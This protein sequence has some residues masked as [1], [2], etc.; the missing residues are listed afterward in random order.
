MDTNQLV[1]DINDVQNY[2]NDFINIDTNQVNNLSKLFSYINALNNYTNP[3]YINEDNN[4]Y[5]YKINNG[6]ITEINKSTL[7]N[8]NELELMSEAQWILSNYNI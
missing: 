8:I 1:Q 5:Y 3:I 4:Y 2:K 6:Y 7:S